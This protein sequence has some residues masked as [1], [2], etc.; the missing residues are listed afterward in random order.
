MSYR[1]MRSAVWFSVSRLGFTVVFCA[2]P[3]VADDVSWENPT[4][5]DFSN[6]INWS[7]GLVP[8]V[9]DDVFFD[10]TSIYTVSFTGDATNARASR[11]P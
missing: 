7:T 6:P 2:A 1:R 5:G 11:C 3:A 4:G 9:R 10:L 8:G